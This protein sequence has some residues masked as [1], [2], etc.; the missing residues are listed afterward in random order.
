M[1]AES[2]RDAVLLVSGQMNL[3]MGGPGVKIPIEDEIKE[4]IFTEAEVVDLWPVDLDPNEFNRRSLFIYR[5][6]NVHYAM[7]DA[8]DAPDTQSPCPVRSVSTHAPQALV[9]L[10]SSFTQQAAG[11]LARLYESEN[12]LQKRAI[13][14]F[15]Q[16][17]IRQPTDSEMQKILGFLGESPSN[18]NWTD[19][20]LTLLNLN[21]FIYVP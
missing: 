12:D 5:K 2:L 10:N 4:L 8:F 18:E 17:L 16:V 20:A 21:E 9:L 7:Y 19:F 1:E 13:A 6:R 3:K 15:Q 14:M 11:H